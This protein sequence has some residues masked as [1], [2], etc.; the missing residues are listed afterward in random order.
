MSSFA[1]ESM[2]RR[3]SERRRL[4]AGPKQ[5]T[6]AIAL[7]RSIPRNATVVVRLGAASV[8]NRDSW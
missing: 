3:S 4:G 2:R 1:E 8:G 6:L 7:L 5:P